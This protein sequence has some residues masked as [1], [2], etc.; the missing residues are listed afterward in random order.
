VDL[1]IFTFG[2]RQRSVVKASL[3]LSYVRDNQ[4]GAFHL[5][6]NGRGVKL[7]TYLHIMPRFGVVELYLHCSISLHGVVLNKLGPRLTLLFFFCLL[8]KK[9]GWAPESVWVWWQRE[10]SLPPEMELRFNS[11]L[12]WSLY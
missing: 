10:K 6:Q 3:G 11:W 1:Q 5:E 9:S 8:D 12:A 2:T 7:T 4:P